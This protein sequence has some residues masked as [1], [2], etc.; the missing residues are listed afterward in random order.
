MVRVMETPDPIIGTLLNNNSSVLTLGSDEE[1]NKY[2]CGV[3]RVF[4][5]K[6]TI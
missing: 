6:H 3:D 2:E 1:G 5:R 4:A